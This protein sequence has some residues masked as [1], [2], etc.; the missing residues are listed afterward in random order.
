ML[1]TRR[2]SSIFQSRSTPT[3]LKHFSTSVSRMVAANPPSFPFARPQAWDPPLEYAQLRKNNPISRVELW[4]GSHP[5]LVV[6]HKD[7]VSVLTDDRL[8]K[9]LSII[10]NQEFTY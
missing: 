7:V 8:S 5:W 10:R 3:L 9:V 2:T 6:K 4:D 1:A